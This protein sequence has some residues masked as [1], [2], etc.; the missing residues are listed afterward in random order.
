M[1]HMSNK[2]L[3]NTVGHDF[4]EG[5]AVQ[6]GRLDWLLKGLKKGII[7]LLYP[8]HC[9]HCGQAVWHEG[10]WCEAC[11]KSEFH[12][13]QIKLTKAS[14]LELIYVLSDYDNGVK[15]LI[16]D[17]K[18]NKKP[19]RSQW[20]A[21]FL[22]SFSIALAKGDRQYT[23][24]TYDYVIPI[25]VSPKKILE[26][27][28]NQVDIIFKSWTTAQ[29]NISIDNDMNLQWLDCLQKA[30][31]TKKMYA[32]GRVERQANIEKAFS[33][34]LSIKKQNILRNKKV[35]LVDDIYTTGATLEAAA[36][37]LRDEGGC[38]SVHGL[39]ITGG[40]SA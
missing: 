20:L 25:P 24:N 28:Y 27:G 6:S 4:V 34:K 11:F 2:V 7:S 29:G 1:K 23:S 38:A 9:P 32:L 12:M 3:H 16:R 31:S 35:L 18:F 21:P 17:I 39:A 26:R 40:H 8:P 36:K 37:V 33:L 10:E 22:L 13:K 14:S 30:D 15:E 5:S 19:E